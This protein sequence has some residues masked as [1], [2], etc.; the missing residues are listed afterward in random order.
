MPAPVRRQVNI[1]PHT[2]WDREWYKPY[3]LFRMQLVELLDDLL[4]RLEGDGS[5]AHFQL[6]GQLAVVDDYLEIRSDQAERITALNES[7]RLSF[8][9][10]YT[11]PDE[12]LVSGETHV[13][14]LR[15]GL[16]TAERFGGS[17]QVGY[18]PDMFGHVAQMPQILAGFG[19]ADAVV[20]RGVPAAIDA[21]GFWWEA[22][23]GTRVR[24][25]Y[26]SDGYGNGARMPE[27]GKELI[28]KIDAFREAQGNKVGD[29]IL[30]MNGTDH[31]LP[32]PH[33]GRVVAE[34]NEAS[35]DYHLVVTS[36]AEHIAAMPREGLPT[37]RGELR[38]GARSNL[39]MGVA[40]CRVDVK[41]AAARA[42]R[43]L[44]RVA[45][46]LTTCWQP[47]DAYPAAFLAYAWR[48]VIRNAAHDSI[49]GCS[50][51]EVN[52]AVLHRYA[53]STR[54]AEAI[55][56]R[57][58]IRVLAESGQAAVAVNPTSRARGAMVTAIIT[59]DVAP[60]HTQQLSVR[61]AVDRTHTITRTTAVPVVQRLIID[62]PKVSSA[63]V[64]EHPDGTV[65]ATFQADGGP[66]LQDMTALRLQLEALADADPEGVVHLDI[67]RARATQEVLLRTDPVPG[68]GW[69]GLAPADLGEHAVRSEGQG[70]TNG[71]VT[72]VPD[73][74][75]GTFRLNG[76]AGMGR[77]VDDGDEGDTYNWSPPAF[78]GAIERPLDVDVLVTEAGPVRGRM[79]ITRRYRWP[80]RIEGGRRVGPIDVFVRTTVEL[81][82][83]EDLVRV[84]VRF[85]NPSTDHRVRAWFPLPEPATGSEAECAFGTVRRGLTAE[86]GPNE[87]GLPTFPSRRFVSA[88][89]L[90]I[91]HDGLCEY[92]LVDIEGEG[93][94]ARASSIAVTLLRCVG[95][96][97][98][99]PMAMRAL[100]AGPP[101]PTPGA[102]MIGPHQADLVLH[103]GGRDPYAVADEAFTPILTAR[104]PGKDGLGDPDAMAG[105][106]TVDGAEVTALTRRPDGRV[107]L[108][109]VN[110]TDEPTTVAVA[111]RTGRLTDLDGAE[112]G[113][114]FTGSLELRPHQIQTIALD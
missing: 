86:G 79:Q 60:P 59:G 46:P 31:L 92:E 30:W 76:V 70:L 91:A 74:S 34:A 108:R 19:L 16:A 24:A 53:E 94:A 35:D 18:L 49:C 27:H 56:E 5:F 80:T 110:T 15:L 61:D 21:P 88:G 42:E 51:D 47:A 113:E 100:P 77:I 23:D 54:V 52:D 57:A 28:E 64:V 22:P 32:Q 9:P 14:N 25:E 2:H 26:L 11:L 29:A 99:G 97:S 6:D 12:F 39:L 105:A 1:V 71:L 114:P 44:E 38:S 3:P 93:D 45:E 109:V 98:A 20:W 41:Q 83:G 89:G 40:S 55:A 106:L 84:T 67:A 8:G 68:F 73:Q 58:L 104:F 7:G 37:W 90:T 107:E 72:I 85:D 48:D 63:E 96:I 62:D 69:R 43:W 82:A 66:K 50:A 75:D 78:D 102:Q 95:L 81:R 10:W 36:L 33:L 103:V 13:R 101:T 112:T 111:G 65:V 17:M 4:P 87:V